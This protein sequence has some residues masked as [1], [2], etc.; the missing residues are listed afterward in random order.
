MFLLFDYLK[1]KYVSYH[2]VVSNENGQTGL[3]MLSLIF[4]FAVRKY[5]IESSLGCGITM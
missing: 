3:L 4:V 2:Q 5:Q 1:A